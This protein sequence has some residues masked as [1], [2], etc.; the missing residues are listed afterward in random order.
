MA[1]LGLSDSSKSELLATLDRLGT[2]L[3]TVQAGE[4]IGRGSAALPETAAEMIA[5]IGS[6]EGTAAVAPVDA[7]VYRTD[8]MPEDCTGGLSVQAVDV[9]LLDTLAATFQSGK[10]FDH[11][12]S[13]TRPGRSA[14]SQ[15]IASAST[16][17]QPRCGSGAGGSR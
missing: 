6:V 1:V 14:R 10:W 17:Y 13:C 16:S 11:V 9:T 4:G 8:L 7:S 12:S 15:P 2:N 5:R 3:V